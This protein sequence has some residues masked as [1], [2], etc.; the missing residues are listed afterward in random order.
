MPRFARLL[1]CLI[2]AALP[3]PTAPAFAISPQ[4]PYRSFNLSGINYGSMQWERAQRQGKRVWPYSNTPSRSY[5]GSRN[6]VVTAGGFVGGGGGAII[7][8][9]GYRSS[10]RVQRR[11]RR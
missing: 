11:S 3:L 7:Q 8:G 10:P 6:G 1:V 9:S 2:A 4:N 5:S